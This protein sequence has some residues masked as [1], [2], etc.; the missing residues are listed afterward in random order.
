MDTPQ[1]A[2]HE[3]T[4]INVEIA[5]FG[6]KWADAAGQVKRLEEQV[7]SLEAQVRRDLRQTALWEELKNVAE[8]DAEVRLRVK[9][10]NPTIY[11]S[12]AL[13][14]AVNEE[15][16]KLFKTLDRRASNAQSVLAGMREEQGIRD[17]LYHD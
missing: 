5:K 3:I 1:S 14:E 9:E 15:S 12:L 11:E 2:V 7:A 10:D 8:R 6:H 4:S 16:S 13:A 17:F